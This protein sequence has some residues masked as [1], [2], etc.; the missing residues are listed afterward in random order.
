MLDFNHILINPKADIQFFTPG[1]ASEQLWMRPR[2]KKFL[3]IICV[4]GGG[5]GGGG[6]QGAA[7]TAA[8]GG[9]GGAGAI[10][11]ALFN[12]LFLPDRLYVNPG[13]GGVGSTGAGTAGTASTVKLIGVSNANYILLQSNGGSGG[14]AASGATNGTL[15][16]GGSAVT[17][18]NSI[19]GGLGFHFLALQNSTSGTSVA[20][21]S[22]SAASNTLT[23]PTTGVFTTG[24]TG[25]GA[26]P[27][28]NTAG[29]AGGPIQ[30]TSNSLFPVTFPGGAG[31]AA[32]NNPGA[33]GSNGIKIPGMLFFYGGTGGG[34]GGLGAAG[35]AAA[36]G[37]NG[38]RG[39][40]GC[41]GG[42]GG[43]GFTGS[44]ASRGGN[45]GDGFVMMIAW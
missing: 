14:G 9:G 39:A 32:G 34:S 25:G 28:L 38:G 37:G 4:G 30:G 33:N 35:S 24:G 20:G 11:N 27:A 1:Q 23:L 21:H 41:G 12:L 13:P 22:G 31:G 44:T 26:L 29:V 16:G 2:N 5:A 36:S 18:S 43:G 10:A 17:V 6:A 40:Y 42:G 8:G 19:L 45:G 15:G 7:S 3:Q